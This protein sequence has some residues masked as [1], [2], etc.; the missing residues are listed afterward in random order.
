MLLI[1]YF[2]L[3]I[4]CA[5][6]APDLDRI[7]HHDDNVDFVFSYIR[8]GTDFSEKVHYYEDLCVPDEDPSVETFKLTCELFLRLRSRLY[9]DL[10]IFDEHSYESLHENNMIQEKEHVN[11][12]LTLKLKNYFKIRELM[13]L[14]FQSYILNLYEEYLDV[15]NIELTEVVFCN[16][17][18]DTSEDEHADLDD[19]LE[20]EFFTPVDDKDLS[21]GNIKPQNESEDEGEYDL[22]SIFSG[23]SMDDD[24]Y[25]IISGTDSNLGDC[26]DGSQNMADPNKPKRRRKH[27]PMFHVVQEFHK[28]KRKMKEK[29]LEESEKTSQI[30]EEPGTAVKESAKVDLPEKGTEDNSG[31][32]SQVDEQRAQETP[33]TEKIVEDLVK[34]EEKSED[35]LHQQVVEDFKKEVEGKSEQT[36]EQK[37]SKTDKDLEKEREKS[38]LQQKQSYFLEKAKESEKDEKKSVEQ[39][40]EKIVV[41]D[42]QQY[43]SAPFIPQRNESYLTRMQRSRSKSDLSVYSNDESQFSDDCR[44][45]VPS[46]GLQRWD[47]QEQLSEYGESESNWGGRKRRIFLRHKKRKER[48]FVISFAFTYD[49]DDNLHI[50]TATKG[51]KLAF[52]SFLARK[53]LNKLLGLVK[54]YCPAAYIAIK[55]PYEVLRNG[56]KFLKWY[57]QM[58]RGIK[59]RASTER[60]LTFETD[61]EKRLEHIECPHERSIAPLKEELCPRSTDNLLNR[62]REHST[63]AN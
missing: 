41:T 24:G 4:G 10:I 60:A 50:D 43:T 46:K 42:A 2:L 52:G 29:A 22:R 18:G 15:E 45:L 62:L 49:E 13:C 34:T 11:S 55:V 58:K 59:E 61:Q 31:E 28:L 16:L 40:N 19:L 54:N 36:S 63:S 14:Q 20:K 32:G 47:S 33:Q 23:D 57:R 48:T 51:D 38:I 26:P 56:P 35:S 44:S 37:V 21:L 30:G 7:F 6:Q 5:D 17:Q 39:S 12:K 1:F 3:L 25:S 53:A 27:K 8:D 9:S